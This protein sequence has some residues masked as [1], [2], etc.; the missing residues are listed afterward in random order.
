MFKREKEE[1]RREKTERTDQFLLLHPLCVIGRMASSSMKAL[2][3]QKCHEQGEE[4][5]TRTA[6][7]KLYILVKILHH[8]IIQNYFSNKAIK[9]RGFGSQ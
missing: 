4:I 7:V 6:I 9:L 1:E 3:E 8:K 2:S 5:Q